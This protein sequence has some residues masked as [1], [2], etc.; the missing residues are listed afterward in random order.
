MET[1]PY[2][3]ILLAIL[4]AS[5]LAGCAGPTRPDI[6]AQLP[7]LGKG[8]ARVVFTR[9]K[10]VAGAGSPFIVIDIGEQIEP[11][12]MIHLDDLTLEQVLG[13]ENIASER[14]ALIDFLWFD[15]TT[16]KPLYCADNGPDC[17]VYHWRWPRQEQGG[18]LFGNGVQ[19]RENCF[20]IYEPIVDVDFYRSIMSHELKPVGVPVDHVCI[21]DHVLTPHEGSSSTDRLDMRKV[22][23]VQG[24]SYPPDTLYLI[25][26]QFRPS[27]PLAGG[28][29]KTV[30]AEILTNQK[31]SRQV[32]VL[33]STEVGETLIWDRK[34][35]VMRLGSVWYDGV[36]FMPRNVEVE[37]GKTYY[38]HYT[39]RLGQRWEL[40]RVE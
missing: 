29:F 6:P 30:T 3:R 36:G 13:Q 15:P 12:A 28:L 32:Q 8:M 10:Q 11:N 39:T 14:G 38:V 24:F 37:A 35:G 40:K 17:I 16:V 22:K 27:A 25:T 5:Y 26:G 1:H 9:E 34:P 19:I 31:L 33:G 7:S 2:L 20:V 4:F 18:L 21:K 23:R